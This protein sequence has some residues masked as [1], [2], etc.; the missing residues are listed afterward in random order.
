MKIQYKTSL[1]SVYR[2][3]TIFQNKGKNTERNEKKLKENHRLK[4]RQNS[5]ICM[6]AVVSW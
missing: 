6:S 2:V 1:T 5:F 4:L 3:W